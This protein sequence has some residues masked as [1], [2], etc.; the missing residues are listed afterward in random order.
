MAATYSSISDIDV[1]SFSI[2]FE[3]IFSV[4]LNVELYVFD[5]DGLLI[6]H[7][8]VW[9]GKANVPMTE[10]ELVSAQIFVGPAL[11]GRKITTLAALEEARFCRV[12]IG[13]RPGLRHYHLTA[14]PERVWRWWLIDEVWQREEM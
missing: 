5:G 13:F 7:Q 1:F 6:D 9:R 14:I 10:D 3:S 2:A 11:A 12:A 4:M 8:P